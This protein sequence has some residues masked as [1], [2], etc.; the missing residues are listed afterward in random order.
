MH[1]CALTNDKS[2]M[3]SEYMAI[4]T[5]LLTAII[6]ILHSMIFMLRR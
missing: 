5:H 6:I 2:N 3:F 1:K 4:P